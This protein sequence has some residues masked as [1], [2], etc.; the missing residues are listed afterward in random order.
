[1]SASSTEPREGTGKLFCALTLGGTTSY[2]EA[3]VAPPRSPAG[4][5]RISEDDGEKMPEARALCRATYTSSRAFLDPF[6][7]C[8][9]FG[10][11]DV[12]TGDLGAASLNLW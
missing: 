5:R 12:S 6:D 9:H 8:T 2:G 4:I 1:M 7:I 10:P 11:I 3:T